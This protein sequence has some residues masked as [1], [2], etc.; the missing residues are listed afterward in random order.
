MPLGARK[1][2]IVEDTISLEAMIERAMSELDF[3]PVQSGIMLDKVPRYVDYQY[4]KHK[5][6]VPSDSVYLAGPGFPLL[7]G[8][9]DRSH[10]GIS[11]LLDIEDWWDTFQVHE[12]NDTLKLG[13]IWYGYDRLREDALDENL[14]SFSVDR[15]YDVPQRP[16]HPYVTDTLFA[17]AIMRFEVSGAQQ[18]IHY[19]PSL[20]FS[21]ILSSPPDLELDLG[22]GQ[23]WQSIQPGGTISLTLSQDSLHLIRVRLLNSTGGDWYGNAAVWKEA[24]V[25]NLGGMN[26]T[27]HFGMELTA[28]HLMQLSRPFQEV[29][30]MSFITKIVMNPN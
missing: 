15:F 12:E 23:G 1:A 22:D 19:D 14:L 16:E 4:F 21:N 3:S 26:R 5:A 10:T 18:L 27:V 6:G 30:C 29:H 17:P 25:S 13:L 20:Y 11:P 7:Y 9:I 2:Q 28:F 24:G 8:M